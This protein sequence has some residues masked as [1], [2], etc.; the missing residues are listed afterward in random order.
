MFWIFWLWPQ[1]QRTLHILLRFG[2]FGGHSDGGIMSS[3]SCR[4]TEWPSP[5]CSQQVPNL[6]GRLVMGII[7]NIRILCIAHKTI[8]R[9]STAFS[10]NL[11]NCN[12]YF[13]LW[14]FVCLNFLTCLSWSEKAI[15]Q[16][17]NCDVII[18]VII[19]KEYLK[20]NTFKNSQSTASTKPHKRANFH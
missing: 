18:N 10:G 7:S 19:C 1:C 15:L 11:F 2:L 20:I 6:V 3:D 5:L 4:L 9:M 13:E 12:N 17:I 16:T 14:A 8:L